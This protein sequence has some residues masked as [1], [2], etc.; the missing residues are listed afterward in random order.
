MS[1]VYLVDLKEIMGRGL[2]G[3]GKTLKF[4]FVGNYLGEDHTVFH[5]GTLQEVD[6]V[7][8]LSFKGGVEVAFNLS[9]EFTKKTTLLGLANIASKLSGLSGLIF[10]GKREVKVGEDTLK[11]YF[12]VYLKGSV[13]TNLF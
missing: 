7:S 6:V 11:Q 5:R 13:H 3:E 9:G 4:D 1:E 8:I 12:Y 10:L 2:V